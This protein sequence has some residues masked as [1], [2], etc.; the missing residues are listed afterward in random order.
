MPTGD[1]V[2]WFTEKGPS[3]NQHTP[4]SAVARDGKIYVI[5]RKDEEIGDGEQNWIATHHL[6]IFDRATFSFSSGPDL[7][8]DNSQEWDRLYHSG[9]RVG[10]FEDRVIVVGMAYEGCGIPDDSSEGNVYYTLDEDD[11]GGS[12]WRTVV[13]S[14]AGKR[15]SRCDRCGD[16]RGWPGRRRKAEP[17]EDLPGDF[18]V[19]P[20]AA[21]ATVCK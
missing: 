20:G 13:Y 1:A 8:S 11:D 14:D 4:L 2:G 7:P 3:C 15:P 17:G 16:A 10:V 9:I 21:L 6:H 5:S 12:R 18:R 19:C